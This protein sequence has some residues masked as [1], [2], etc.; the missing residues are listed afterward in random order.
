MKQTIRLA[1]SLLVFTFLVPLFAMQTA[2]AQNAIDSGGGASTTCTKQP[3]VDIGTQNEGDCVKKTAFSF[4]ACGNANVSISCLVGEVMKFL[5]VMVG[6]A[7]V[8]GITFGGITYSTG[9][10]NAAKTQKGVTIIVNS[11][12]GLLVYLLMF[13]II[14]F[15]IPGGVF[16]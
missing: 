1:I 11:V 4:G 16:S 15:L 3:G 10:G 7:V 14:N 2:H 5:T 8:G 13:A 12:I 9:S 6:I